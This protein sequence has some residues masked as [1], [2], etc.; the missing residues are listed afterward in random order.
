MSRVAEKN[1]TKRQKIRKQL[2]LTQAQVAEVLHIDTRTVF[3]IESGINISKAKKAY[4]GLIDRMGGANPK[5][6]TALQRLEAS[7]ARLGYCLAA[8]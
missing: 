1:L 4:N 8:T 3:I 7:A 2:G 5:G 6:M